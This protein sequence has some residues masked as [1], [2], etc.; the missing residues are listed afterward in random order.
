VTFEDDGKNT[1]GNNT[2]TSA[3]SD[4]DRY[5]AVLVGNYARDGKENG[6]LTIWEL[7]TGRKVTRL[8]SAVPVMRLGAFSPSMRL[9]ACVNSRSET[10][11]LLE[12]RT[13]RWVGKLSPDNKGSHLK[14]HVT[15]S[16][17]GRLVAAG[18]S[19]G[20]VILW[21]VSDEKPLAQFQGHRGPVESLC[22]S[23]D[24]KQL[25]T[26]GQNDAAILVW[27]VAQWTRR[28]KEIGNGVGEF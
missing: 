23:P 17:D 18:T 25:V 24:G 21:N 15:F 20:E 12:L 9:L 6:T 14:E 5:F 10:I 7:A 1:N 19:K 27:D 13:G 28:G 11:D 4:D 3:F 16:P 8:P 22:F 2:I 26:G